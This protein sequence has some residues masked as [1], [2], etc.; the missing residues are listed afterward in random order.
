MTPFDPAAKCPKC[1]HDE[2]SDAYHKNGYKCPFGSVVDVGREEE[3]IHRTCKR[4]G[5][6]WPEAVLERTKERR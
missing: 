2:T 5:F 6:D 4:C 3:H 1:G